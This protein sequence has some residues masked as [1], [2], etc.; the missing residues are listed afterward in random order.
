LTGF[1][2]GCVALVVLLGLVLLLP[3]R[4]AA[5][6]AA[7]HQRANREWLQLR[8]RELAAEAP[9]LA[10]QLTDDAKLRLLEDWQDEQPVPAVVA[11]SPLRRWPLPLAIAALAAAIYQLLGAAPD[12]VIGQ[13]IRV[14]EQAEGPPPVDIPALIQR[15]EQRSAQRP[16]NLQYLSLL[17][18]IYMSQENY[19]L[20]AEAYDRLARR[21]PGDPEIQAM[22]AQSSFLAY[23]RKL[24]ETGQLRAENALALDPGQATALGLLGMA[25]FERGQYRAAI[26]YWQRLLAVEPPGSPNAEVINDVI[27]RAREALLAEGGEIPLE[28]P[29]ESAPAVAGLHVAVRVALPADARFSPSDTVFVLARS[30]E[31][32]SR[33]PVAVRRLSVAD[34]PMLVVLGDQDAMAGQ[35]LSAMAEVKVFV[36]VSPTGQPGDAN[37]SYLGETEVLVPSEDFAPVSLRWAPN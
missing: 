35:A 21:V 34:L 14:V 31:A 3:S 13:Q 16:D 12:V 22:A 2:L 4:R 20:A 32:G 9:E 11:R 10:D 26:D 25:A 37:A 23:G 17:A 30:P 1:L 28:I 24:D 18:R 27:A 5:S 7:D 8:Q 6:L 29:L 15:I 33:M 36:Q 19:P